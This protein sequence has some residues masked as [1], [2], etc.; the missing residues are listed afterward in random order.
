MAAESVTCGGC[1]SRF[2]ADAAV[3]GVEVGGAVCP[4]E[5]VEGGCDVF[6][7][8]GWATGEGHVSGYG[9]DV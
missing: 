6:R 7:V 4:V 1:S 8:D 3:A 5:S 2:D 9:G